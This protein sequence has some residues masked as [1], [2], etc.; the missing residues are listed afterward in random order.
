MKKKN[1]IQITFYPQKGKKNDTNH[2]FLLNSLTLTKSSV[3]RSLEHFIFRNL[4]LP[5]RQPLKSTVLYIYVANFRLT[6]LVV[7]HFQASRPRFRQITSR[8]LVQNE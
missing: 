7:S 2:T 4:P 1:L 6:H 5:P 3:F 8:L